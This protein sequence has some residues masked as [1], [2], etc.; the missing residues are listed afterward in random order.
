MS[1][2]PPKSDRKDLMHAVGSIF[3]GI[4]CSKVKGEFCRI[5]VVLYIQKLL[6]KDIFVVTKL[7]KKCWVPFKYENFPS[8]YFGC[9]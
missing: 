3:G 8:Y 9:G 4:L 6:H 1:P 5:K 2:C 7:Q